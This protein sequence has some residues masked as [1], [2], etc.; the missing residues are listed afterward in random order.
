MKFSEIV[1]SDLSKIPK[2]TF[3]ETCNVKF[4]KK[5]ISDMSKILKYTFFETWNVQFSKNTFWFVKT[6]KWTFLETWNVKISKNANFD[7]SKII[8]YTFLE[9]YLSKIL[10][11]TVLKLKAWNI[12][13]SE[14]FKIHF[15]V[16]LLPMFSMVTKSLFIASGKSKDDF[17]RANESFQKTLSAIFG[18]KLPM[19][20]TFLNQIFSL[21]LLIFPMGWIH[22]LKS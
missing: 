11:N 9:T 21:F 7:V 19:N 16:D 14:T 8:K 20:L 18:D 10:K 12:W 5:A 13:S 17:Y 6:P 22:T 15:L 3:L 4:S 2:C 1:N